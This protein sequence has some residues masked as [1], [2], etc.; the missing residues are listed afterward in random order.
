MAVVEGVASRE[1]APEVVAAV[2]APTQGRYQ[3]E[4]GV[5]VEAGTT[6]DLAHTSPG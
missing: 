3:L 6:H 4:V 5:A 1:T 2:A